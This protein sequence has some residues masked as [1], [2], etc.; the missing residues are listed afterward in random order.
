LLPGKLH[1]SAKGPTRTGSDSCTH[2][3]AMKGVVQ[4]N[5]DSEDTIREV[6]FD[7]S[8]RSAVIGSIRAA[9]RAGIQ[10]ANI[11]TTIKA[12]ATPT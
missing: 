3:S 9:R 11:A 8:C 5:P 1:F 2:A 4:S 6:Y 10:L 7:Q 12:T